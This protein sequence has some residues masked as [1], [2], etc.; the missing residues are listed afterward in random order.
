MTRA[1]LARF[2]EVALRRN[3]VSAQLLG[4]C[5]LLAVSNTVANALGLAA[6]SAVVLVGSAGVVSVL[7]KLVPADVRLPCFVLVI[8]TFTTLVNLAMEA[9]AFEL[10]QRIALFVQIIVTNCMILA[11]LEQVAAK[12]TLAHT[13]LDALAASVGFAIAIVALGAARQLIAAGFPLA[14]LPPGAFMIA[15]LLLAGAQFLRQR[16]AERELAD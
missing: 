11:R 13:L 15:G 14:A 2:S 16:N 5:P 9:Y 12:E 1:A 6:A 7:R 3:P 8:A 4:L 10:H